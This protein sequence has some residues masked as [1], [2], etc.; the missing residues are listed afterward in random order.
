MPGRDGTGPVGRGSM[1]GRGLG[2]CRQP[3]G[4]TERTFRYGRGNGFGRGFAR[5]NRRFVPVELIGDDE[6]KEI[7]EE[8]KE[9]LKNRL[10]YIKEELED[11]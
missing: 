1:T 6:K 11:L 9:I 4:S 3:A 8:E 5:V 7:L 10:E 2:Y